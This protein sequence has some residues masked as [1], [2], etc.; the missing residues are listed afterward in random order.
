MFFF[1]AL[2]FYN[3]LLF[4]FVTSGRFAFV[5]HFLWANSF[6]CVCL[7]LTN[8]ITVS[9]L[10]LFYVC[11]FEYA[12][13]VVRAANRLINSQSN[14]LCH[15]QRVRSVAINLK[16]NRTRWFFYFFQQMQSIVLWCAY[17]SFHHNTN[18]K[19]QLMIEKKERLSL[20][21]SVNGCCMNIVK[22]AIFDEN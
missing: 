21:Q 3:F 22:S 12:L 17:F 11:A 4:K 8:R 13:H 7:W 16:L 5:I 19:L 14:R 1:F 20:Y 9:S 18:I 6:V 10:C 15:L 2:N